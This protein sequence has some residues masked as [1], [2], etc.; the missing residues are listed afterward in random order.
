M[1]NLIMSQEEL[2]KKI[3]DELV[4]E[5]KGLTDELAIKDVAIK[6]WNSLTDRIPNENS[7]RRA[8]KTLRDAVRTVYPDITD[9]SQSKPVG[10]YFTDSKDS[11]PRK[12]PRFEHLVLWYLTTNTDRR[13]VVGDEAREKYFSQW[14][15][16]TKPQEK[17]QIKQPEIKP[18]LPTLENMTINTLELDAETQAI[19]EASLTNS[20]LSL[21][22]FIKQAVKVYA[23]TIEGKS[24]QHTSDLSTVPTSELLKNPKYK[25]HPVRARESVKRAIQAIKIFNT[26]EPEPKNRWVITQ[27]AIQALT[28]SKPATVKEILV[29]YQRDID[30]YNQA[31][32]LD[33][34]YLNRKP[35]QRIEE[36]IDVALLVPDGID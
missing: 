12:T 34:P 14:D 21:P 30:D 1:V 23:K 31:H 19:V 28:G 32:G 24:K 36:V 2:A 6:Y 35:G 13:E 20:G 10:Y 18:T 26:N 27:T 16:D 29:D 8:R 17:P 9:T 5:L 33:S 15:T 7:S 25:T 3:G 4:K 11:Y 22:E